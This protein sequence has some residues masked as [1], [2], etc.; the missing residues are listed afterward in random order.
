M[1]RSSLRGE[2]YR[3]HSLSTKNKVSIY[4]MD[5]LKLILGLTFIGEVFRD[6]DRVL[7]RYCS[8]LALI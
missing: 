5:Q 3:N 2:T 1:V 6:I 7:L 8:A 4:I